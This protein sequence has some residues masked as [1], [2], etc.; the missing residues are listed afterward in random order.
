M[1]AFLW[2]ASA[3]LAAEQ[4]PVH[5]RIDS[6]LAA[7][8]P[9]FASFAASRCSDSEFHRRIHLDLVGRIPSAKETREFLDDDTSTKRETLIDRLLADPRHARRMQYVFDE[10]LMAR[11]PATNVPDA[12]WR[13]Y[14]RQSFLANKPWNQLVLEILSADG[15]D[16]Q[17]RPAARFYLDRNFD[18]DLLTRDIGRVFLGVDLECAQCHDHPAIDTYLQQ[19][20]YG[21]NAFLSRSYLFT[22]PKNKQ[23]QL[24]EK[25]EGDVKFTSVFTQESSQTNP[26]MLD[27]PEIPDPSESAKQYLVKPDKK[28]RGVPTYSRRLK[29]GQ[30][31]IAAD[32]IDFRRNIVNRLWAIM[33]GR[34]LVEPLD[35]RHEQNP[36]S[37]PAVLELLAEEF[38]QHNYDIRWMLK[39]LALTEAYQRSSYAA[40]EHRETAA[41]NFAVGLLKPQSPEQL[42]WSIMQATGAADAAL[43]TKEAALL[44]SDPKFGAGRTTHPLWREEA[45]HDALKANVDQ[46]ALKFA[47][48]NGQ[49][50]S[51]GA[52]ANQALFLMNG[53]LVDRWLLPGSNNLT[54]RLKKQTEPTALADELYLSVLCRKPTVAEVAEVTEY[55]QTVGDRDAG[56]QEFVWALLSSAEFRFNH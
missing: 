6:L 38:L 3:A 50:T 37:H 22:N 24:G 1:A 21:I 28:S 9:Q 34:G 20:Y 18:V 49:T 2:F 29:L 11:M 7:S 15:A 14:L 17:L 52:T 10:M 41:K 56:I 53:P 4:Q 51:F 46:F 47:G 33:L 8:H 55:F 12:E 31:M 27:L 44:K 48:Q 35:V 13:N 23:K 36:P 45:L 16:P 19:H 30:A 32:N 5:Q 25:A 54:D 39:Q 40:E 42:A 26:R 43:A